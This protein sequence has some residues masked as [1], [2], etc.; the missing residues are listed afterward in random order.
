MPMN[1]VALGAAAVGTIFLYSAIKGKSILATT[2]A[3]IT[4]KNPGTVAQ[5]NAIT[6][7]S[8]GEGS[9]S[10]G[11]QSSALPSAGSY[12]HAQV[13]SLW[14]SLGGSQATANNAACHAMQES[15]GNPRATSSNPDGGE[16]VGLFQLDTK[17][18]GA[19]QSVTA[20]QNAENNTRITI[21]ATK[22]GADWSEWSTPGC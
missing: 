6:A 12:S 5:S 19:G 17:G 4:G 3:I 20:L 18:V 1:G 16:N 14:T 9:N 13:M 15:S 7:V 8:A 11:V 22:N 10:L 21:A 2:Q